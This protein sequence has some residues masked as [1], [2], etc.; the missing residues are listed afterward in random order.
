MSTPFSDKEL[1]GRIR[2]YVRVRWFFVSAIG[3][4]GILALVVY[5]GFGHPQVML[6]IAIFAVLLLA[7]CFVYLSTRVK[8]K[9][10][11]G[12]LSVFQVCLDIAAMTAVFQLN[13]GLETPLVMLYC[14]PILMSGVL[15]SKRAV[16]VTGFAA[17]AIFGV[18]ALLDFTDV[19]RPSNVLA[20]ALHETP[21]GFFP[22]FV[23]TIMIL[24][25]ITSITNLVAYYVR[26]SS[27]LEGE[28]AGVKKEEA[29]V[30]AIIQSMGSSLVAMDNNGKIILTNN[31]FRKLVGWRTEEVMGKQALDVLKVVSDDNKP[32][33]DIEKALK[34]VFDHKKDPSQLREPYFVGDNLLQRKNGSTFS[35]TGHLSAIIVDGKVEGATFVF[36]DASAIREVGQLKS[37]FIA[38]ASHQLKT[39]IGEIK[40]YSENMLW[41]V[42]GKLN[43]KQQSYIERMRDIATRCN[44][45][46]TYLLDM[47]L[48]ERGELRAK[49]QPI[50][51]FPLL[52]SIA[53]LYKG[54]VKA[55]GLK[56]KVTGDPDLVI[57][58]DEMMLQEVVGSL[59]AN[60]ISYTS[61]GT[62]ELC[63]TTVGGIGCI[64]V[65]DEGDGIDKEKLQQIFRK[66]SVLAGLPEAGGGT[67]LGL[68]LAY[69]FV[70]LQG[71]VLMADRNGDKGTIFRIELPIIN[72]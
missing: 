39:P 15:L 63:S 16:Y 72:K 9:G 43:K 29:K 40:N 27:H 2:W 25:V 36:D 54:R 23:T 68:Y 70:R 24:I 18:L 32:K 49:L 10:I 34:T 64:E 4:P 30:E 47:S 58:G 13:G 52:E 44:Q 37:N 21:E 42:T 38:L 51:V 3:L 22:T 65:T 60:G 56:I 5:L 31:A 48:L 41:G 46:V 59:I 67:G 35:Y 28:L 26:Q 57:R 17:T 55:K 11:Y 33:A 45:M 53:E 69:E 62:I 7:N 8:L 6:N 20:P 66:E 50:P 19:F 14:I 61:S 12:A 1:I 71:G